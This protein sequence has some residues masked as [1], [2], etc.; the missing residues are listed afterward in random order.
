MKNL[1]ITKLFRDGENL[2]SRYLENKGY[3]IKARNYRTSFGE[4]DVIASHEDIITFIEVKTRS[5]CSITN[6]T[7]NISRA[8]KIK[9]SRSA[10]QYIA[11]LP[12]DLAYETRF[13]VIILFHDTHTDTYQIQHIENAFDPILE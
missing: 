3:D 9:I 11:D 10:L 7:S 12:A 6:A 2:A 8:K 4:I 5:H 13:D 1:R